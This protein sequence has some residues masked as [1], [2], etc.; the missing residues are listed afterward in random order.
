MTAVERR[1]ADPR[2]GL[3]PVISCVVL[4]RG[5]FAWPKSPSNQSVVER[6]RDHLLNSQNVRLGLLQDRPLPAKLETCP[7]VEGRRACWGL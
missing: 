6:Q 5:S 3:G 7:D 4:T 2:V 1:K